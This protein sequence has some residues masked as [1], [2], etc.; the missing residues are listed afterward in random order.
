V[1]CYI[2]AAP[3]GRQVG[4]DVAAAACTA[5]MDRLRNVQG[6]LDAAMLRPALPT[7]GLSLKGRDGYLLVTPGAEKVTGLLVVKNETD[8]IGNLLTRTVYEL[9]PGV[10]YAGYTCIPHEKQMQLT[11][12]HAVNSPHELVKGVLLR[13]VLHA[14][15]VF[16]QIKRGVR[17]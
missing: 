11:V 4:V 9:V 13:A 7:G 3:A 2:P 1:S 5:V 10:G 17:G 6:I 12:V 15:A 14:Y 16:D 8:T